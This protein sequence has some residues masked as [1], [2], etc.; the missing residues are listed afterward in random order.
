MNVSAAA[1]VILVILILDV[2][3]FVFFMRLYRER[4]DAIMTALGARFGLSARGGESF[5][6]GLPVVR[7]LRR[8]IWLEGAVGGCPLRIFHYTGS[9]GNRR[10]TFATARMALQNKGGLA[11]TISR[12]GLRAGIAKAVGMYQIRLG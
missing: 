4:R 1:S 10:T 9:S 6:P 3:F 7:L 2:V 12:E 5:L 8:P 11:L